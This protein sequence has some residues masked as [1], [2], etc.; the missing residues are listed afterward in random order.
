MDYLKNLHKALKFAKQLKVIEDS[1]NNRSSSLSAANITVLTSFSAMTKYESYSTT[2]FSVTNHLIC[3]IDKNRIKIGIIT[4][5]VAR[6]SATRLIRELKNILFTINALKYIKAKKLARC[7]CCKL[8]DNNNR[9]KKIRNIKYWYTCKHITK[10]ISNKIDKLLEKRNTQTVEKQHVQENSLSISIQENTSLNTVKDL[11]KTDQSIGTTN[12]DELSENTV[13]ADVDKIIGIHHDMNSKS[14]L[15]PKDKKNNEGKLIM[16]AK[17][18]KNSQLVISQEIME[19]NEM[20]TVEN[21]LKEIN[22][23]I[24][25]IRIKEKLKSS[26]HDKINATELKSTNK[27]WIKFNSEIFEQTN[28]IKLQ[29]TN[30]RFLKP[31]SQPIKSKVPKKRAK[32]NDEILDKNVSQMNPS[33]Q[34]N[35]QKI[36]DIRKRLSYG[37]TMEHRG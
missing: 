11:N 17:K 6:T 1:F 35:G 33:Q 29:K 2:P 20:E 28:I 12:C 18:I 34:N 3:K 22:Q 23:N 21:I 14:A 24:N 16:P 27:N 5:D 7:K 37:N 9:N 25:P 15:S 36:Y 13:Q 32:I 4:E 26:Q 10:I 8:I 30:D 19:E 31:L